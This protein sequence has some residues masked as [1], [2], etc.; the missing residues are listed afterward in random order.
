MSGPVSGPAFGP[1]VGPASRS[2][3]MTR[4]DRRHVTPAPVQLPGPPAAFPNDHAA[5]QAFYF[6]KSATSGVKAKVPPKPEL[7]RYPRSRHLQA[8][9]GGVAWFVEVTPASTAEWVVAW[10][11]YQMGSG[12]LRVASGGRS[13]LS[14]SAT[15]SWYCG[16]FRSGCWER[17]VWVLCCFSKEGRERF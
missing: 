13:G 9:V 15:E 17:C 6:I 7:V 5:P 8:L 1:A 14:E 10:H 3:L 2:G 16:H 11:V 4:R 12:V